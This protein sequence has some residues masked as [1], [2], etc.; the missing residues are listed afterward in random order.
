MAALPVEPQHLL[1]AHSAR[2]AP[3]TS[4]HDV[5]EVTP[6]A[7]IQV[8]ETDVWWIVDQ[9]L[10]I[11]R[12]DDVTAAFA[13]EN[14]I[15]AGEPIDELTPGEQVAILQAISNANARLDPLRRA[16]ERT[17]CDRT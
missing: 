14:G 9:L 10:A 12:A 8:S 5:R 6:I 15:L 1:P 17:H 7:P 11:G 4:V 16:L 3:I 2:L 13:I